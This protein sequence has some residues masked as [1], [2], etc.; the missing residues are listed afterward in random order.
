[1][2][3]VLF[4]S[5]LNLYNILPKPYYNQDKSKAPSCLGGLSGPG[6]ISILDKGRL[7]LFL[8]VSLI[9][10]TLHLMLNLHDATIQNLRLCG[11]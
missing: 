4:S 3:D 6:L 11:R 5:E 1:M 10:R 7:K 9:F 8:P 2:S